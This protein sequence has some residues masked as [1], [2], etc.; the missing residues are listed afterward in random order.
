MPKQTRPPSAA[1]LRL[2]L[3]RPRRAARPGAGDDGS[4]EEGEGEEDDEEDGEGEGE[5]EGLR[6]GYED[7]VTCL[8]RARPDVFPPE[9]FTWKVRVTPTL[10]SRDALILSR[11]LLSCIAHSCHVVHLIL[12]RHSAPVTWLLLAG[13]VT[14]CC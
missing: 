12:P 14:P 5:F 9:A 8:T 4:G 3:R 2:R 11:D 10:R 6:A 13:H 7:V 1:T